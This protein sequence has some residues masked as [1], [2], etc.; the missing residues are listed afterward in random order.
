VVTPTHPKSPAKVCAAIGNFDGV[1]RGHQFLINQTKALAAKH[2]MR[3]GVVL[4]DPHPRRY[5]QPDTPPFL[6]TT[7]D[8]RDHLLREH[9]VEVIHALTFDKA[10]SSLT[11]EAFIDE[12]LID[13]LD[14]GAIMV[15]AEFRFGRGRAGDVT[16]LK[17]RALE[18]GVEVENVTPV[19]HEGGR[20][21]DP[22][23]D[24]IGSSAIRTAIVAGD[25]GRANVMLGYPWTVS[26]PV[27][28]GQKLGRS[29][30]FP[31]ANMQLG[32]IIAPRHGV[33]AVHIDVDGQHYA[34]I[35]NFGRKPTVGEHLPLLEVHLFEFAD[36]LYG[37]TINVAFKAFLRAERRFDGLDVLK[38]Q[39]SRDCD[40]ARAILS[41]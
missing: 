18:R 13:Q 35:A 17:A 22:Q 19:A 38:A 31:T 30:G 28:M 5:F 14:L 3:P 21:G 12:V 37:K 10:L 11:A 27:I 34:G 25:I 26:G 8:R 7:P 2:D 20:T 29:L 1:H 9:G 32:E 33:Y 36:D 4:F 24:K 15:G 23:K 16:V 6:L 41:R 40:Q 39:I